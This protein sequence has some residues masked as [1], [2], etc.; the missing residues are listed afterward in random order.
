MLDQNFSLLELTL[1]TAE[2]NLAL[3][4]V[5]L[6]L[7]AQGKIPPTLRLWELPYSAVIVG[8]SNKLGLN[9]AYD[10]CRTAGVPVIRRTSGGGTV[11]LG[12]GCLVFSLLVPFKEHPGIRESIEL[13]LGRIGN[14]LQ[15]GITDSSSI[16]LEGISDLTID[17]LKFS[18]NS[19]RWI[20]NNCLHHGTILYDF[21]LAQAAQLLTRPER[22]P[23]Y[24]AGRTHLEFITNLSLPREVIREAFITEWSAVSTDFDLPM[25]EIQEL[26]EQKYQDTNWNESR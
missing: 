8:R 25:D 1:P 3:D 17:G 9:V 24:R 26:A 23:E 13:I 6:K 12:P 19:Q 10:A 5:L 7:L 18:G 14:R 15:Q 21:P 20:K 2:E 11:L 16:Q 22:E 4:E